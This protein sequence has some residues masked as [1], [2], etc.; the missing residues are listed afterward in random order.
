MLTAQSASGGVVGDIKTS[1][2]TLS[3]DCLNVTLKKMLL[4][5]SK[6][7]EDGQNPLSL[8]ALSDAIRVSTSV[9]NEYAKNQKSGHYSRS[10]G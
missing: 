6:L 7:L 10:K 8:S 2:Q 1:L 9:V 4:E 3:E 5:P